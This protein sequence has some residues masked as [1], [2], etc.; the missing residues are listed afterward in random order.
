MQLPGLRR[1]PPIS[2]GVE[3]GG[4]PKSEGRSPKADGEGTGLRDYWTTGPRTEGEGKVESRK[5][6]AEIGG[7]G[8]RT[9]GGEQRSVV[10]GQWSVVVGQ[11]SV[12]GRATAADRGGGIWRWPGSGSGRGASGKCAGYAIAR[13]RR[14]CGD[15]PQFPCRGSPGPGVRGFPARAG[16]A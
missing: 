10:S 4:S 5:Q 9:E 2:V 7:R 13:C 3:E 15:G 6:K 8:H 14:R 1:N 12:V 11:W 16:K